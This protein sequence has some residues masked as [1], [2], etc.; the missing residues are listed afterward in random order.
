MALDP[1][2]IASIEQSIKDSVSPLLTSPSKGADLYELYI[3][4]SIIEAARA[5]GATVAFYDVN[6]SPVTSNF[7]FRTSP[8]RI[9]STIQPYT[10]A[11][12]AFPGCPALEAHIGIFV[13]GKSKVIHECDVAVL[14][15]DAAAT[16]R[17]EEVHPKSTQLLLSAEC[18]FYVQSS[19]GVGLA[20]SYL[21]LV[22]EVKHTYRS[23]Y[24]VAVSESN[25]VQRLFA[26]HQKD[27]ETG[28]MPDDPKGR[29]Q[30]L[31]SSFEKGFRDFKL[32]EG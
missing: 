28:V 15:A 14:Y 18:K 19:M 23:C 24:F 4:S 20:R 31:R 13:S 32:R 25:S 22:S 8:G 16:C 26:H 9:F 2:L 17:A 10:H 27:W 3:W 11:H 30:R 1:N 21:G 12:I 6:G 29:P 5:E 7:I